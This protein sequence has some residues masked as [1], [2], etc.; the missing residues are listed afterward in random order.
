MY[1]ILICASLQISKHIGTSRNCKKSQ[2]WF[3]WNIDMVLYDFTVLSTF[4][5]LTISL[6]LSLSLSL[7]PL[8]EQHHPNVTIIQCCIIP[9]IS[10]INNCVVPFSFAPPNKSSYFRVEVKTEFV[11]NLN[12]LSFHHIMI[13]IMNWKCWK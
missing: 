1:E 5:W 12:F 9:K 4:I 8:L 6:S 3:I 2:V 10:W 7:S 11:P 13:I